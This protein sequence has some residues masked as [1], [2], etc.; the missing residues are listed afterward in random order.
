MDRLGARRTA[1]SV[2]AAVGSLVMTAVL[3]TPVVASAR[4]TGA[5][6][7]A[8]G[9]AAAGSAATSA[10][11]AAWT[12]SGSGFGHGVGMSQYGALAQAKAGRSAGQILASYYTGTTYDQVPDTQTILVNIVSGATTTTVSGRSTGTNGGKLTVTAGGRTLTALAGQSVTLHRSGSAV[13]ATCS[14]CSTTSVSG[15][16][17]RVTWDQSRTDLVRGT[18]RYR[19]APFVVT[20][21]PGAATIQG[22][23]QLRLADEYLDQVREVPW[24]WPEAALEAQAAAARSYALRKLRAGV[25][26]ECACHV[27]DGVGD[28]VYGPVPEGSE[29]SFWPRWQTAVRA[30]GS[31]TTGFVPRYGGQII[32][33]LYSSSS[34]GR[35]VNNED[36]FPGATPVPY[37]RSVSD[38]WS[39]TADNPRR[40][41]TT[42]VTGAQL[43]RA[44]G[45]T[46]VVR[47]DLSQRTSAG[48][49]R[50]AV[51]TSSTGAA[52]SLGGEALR[53]ALGLS[54]SSI[55]R[56]T[57]RVSGS[58][59]SD[60][61]AASARAA[62][63]TAS[64]VVIA[65]TYEED[66]AHLVM[67]RPLAGA[68]RAPLLLSGRG[69][70]TSATVRELDRRGSRITRAYVVGGSTLVGSPV[71]SQLR[72]RGIT[73][74]RVGQADKDATGAA[75]VDL[76]RTLGPITV[77]G[78]STQASVPAAGAFG[79]VA[80][81]RREP[82]VWAGATRVGW[83]SRA[84]LRRAG[85]T[86]VRLLG[87]SSRISTAV[88][89]DL[90]GHGLRVMRFAGAGH[91]D[92]SA[93]LAEYFRN[94]YTGTRVVLARTS[95]DR[96][97]D[98]A[99][100]AGY[101]APVL[102]VTTAPGASVTTL[103]QR[104]PQWPT[105]VAFGPSARVGSTTLT[106]VRDA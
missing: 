17:V 23:L 69:Q 76:M 88:A 83:Q 52:R 14:T 104:Q 55:H 56:V 8:A 79:A 71:V 74:T 95:S 46:D 57:E 21:T 43:A 65:S 26:P 6:T 91:G 38:P 94:S 36:A 39:T 44:F 27:V 70:L 47:L 49:V 13:A 89:Q 16:E 20:P 99:L 12:L 10:A 86:T 82:V 100:A 28:Q 92:V 2:V 64:T 25:R 24:A 18:K 106:R 103:V 81:P 80:G 34:G 42:T 7:G 73:V 61:A 75:V 48:T 41:W 31:A 63:S 9:S 53:R 35:T 93:Q 19:H 29:A 54:S 102:V 101:R 3:A 33:A 98:A 45:L 40:H 90:T 105:V 60:L 30:G 50:T 96:T 62:P 11:P 68:L 1:R 97:S 78:V 66:V 32:E 77:A 87:P 4:P 58:S 72:A 51:A 15:T 59:A 67:A 37:L 84:A 22:V 5:A 85:V